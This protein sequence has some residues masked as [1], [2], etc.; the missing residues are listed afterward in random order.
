VVIEERA[1]LL[2][3]IQDEAIR[4]DAATGNTNSAVDEPI[5]ERRGE[6]SREDADETVS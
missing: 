2:T 5:A 1:H 6:A 4:A 3:R